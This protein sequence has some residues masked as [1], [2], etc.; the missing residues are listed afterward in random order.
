[1]IVTVEVDVGISEDNEVEMSMEDKV[2]IEVVVA[3]DKELVVRIT[4][5]GRIGGLI[6]GAPTRLW[7]IY[8]PG[9]I[10]Q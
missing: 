5:V 1:V 10:S 9:R 7:L 2:G 4:G 3:W 6:V 8:A